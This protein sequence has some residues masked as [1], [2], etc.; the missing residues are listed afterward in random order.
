MRTEVPLYL[1]SSFCD[2]LNSV[3]PRPLYE[4]RDK[5]VV[6]F[7]E[8]FWDL[9]LLIHLSRIICEWGQNPCLLPP[10]YKTF[11]LCH[12]TTYY[13]IQCLKIWND[14]LLPKKESPNTWT[15]TLGP[16]LSESCSTLQ[17]IHGP[18]PTE[19]QHRALSYLT[20]SKCSCLLFPN[21]SPSPHWK[22][23]TTCMPTTIFYH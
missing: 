21:S 18:L 23:F 17:L 3:F 8:T 10:N 15:A 13:A 22:N 16:L 4:W 6:H 1:Q 2:S 20:A 11:S 14:S 19:K 9:D 12:T 5:E 7:V